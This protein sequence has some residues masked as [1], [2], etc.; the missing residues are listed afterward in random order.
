MK[1]CISRMRQ[2][3][4]HLWRTLICTLVKLCLRKVGTIVVVDSN[5]G[6][7]SVTI[8]GVV[9]LSAQVN[10]QIQIVVHAQEVCYDGKS[11]EQSS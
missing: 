3:L 11:S 8:N 5:G 9:D 7:C 2:F 4:I 10:H 1:Q 6:T